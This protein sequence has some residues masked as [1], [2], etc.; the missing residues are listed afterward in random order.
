MKKTTN[1]I[2][3]QIYDQYID[4]SEPDMLSILMENIPKLIKTGNASIIT[5]SEYIGSPMSIGYRVAA[6]YIQKF[7]K[8]IKKN[9]R[10][11]HTFEYGEGESSWT[12]YDPMLM[13]ITKY[14]L[15][16]GIYI[17]ELNNSNYIILDT[18]VNIDDNKCVTKLYFIGSK[19]KKQRAKY[20]KF[21]KKYKSISKYKPP[22]MI[23]SSRGSTETIF[24]SFDK[25]VMKDKDRVL[26]YVDNWV[27]NI[28]NYHEKYEMIPKLSILLYGDP[29]TGKSTF[30][31][32]LAKY[33]NISTIR[34][35]DRDF[36]MSN[37]GRYVDKAV[38]AIDDIDCMCKSRKDS[39]GND[40]I[41][42]STLLEFLDNPP[43]F[44]YKAP[45]GIEYPV[46]IIVAT[47]NYYDKLD[48][49]VKRY[50]RFDLQ[51]EMSEFNKDD[52]QEMCDMY[53]I[54]LSDV[55]DSSIKKN[56]KIA[57]AK[58]QALCLNSLD[59]RLKSGLEKHNGLIRIKSRR[60]H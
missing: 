38:Y 27:K 37:R 40:N 34:I 31:K 60:S 55:V 7:N 1:D 32:A 30:Y 45:D 21:W 39:K 19:W 11:P 26:K 29:G 58:L 13:D 44:Q 42:L 25:Y 56:F 36:L 3:D 20:E 57:P 5:Y 15:D 2:V 17:A 24:K 41:V 18:R 23:Y 14:I 35:V 8:S 4:N 47:T 10:K 54:K 52:A 46:Q 33:L 28:P 50:G 6:K 59:S 9:R 12:S 48:P 43:V 49:A 16:D 51:I 22:E 53:N